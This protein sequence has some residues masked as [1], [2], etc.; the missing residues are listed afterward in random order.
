MSDGKDI[1]QVADSLIFAERGKHLTD[2]ETAIIIGVLN[3]C[4][5]SEIANHQECTEGHIKDVSSR[6]WQSF[7][8]LLGEDVTKK[9]LKS[10]LLR[11][12]IFNFSTYGTIN[13]GVIGVANNTISSVTNITIHPSESITNAFLKGKQTAKRE[14]A[15]K[16]MQIG[17]NIDQICQVLDLSIEEINLLI[18]ETEVVW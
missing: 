6:L 12:G 16:M 17:M 14:T 10:T 5:Y 9:N 11:R 8:K 4:T 1:L 3:N 15:I 2:V 13:N 18:G 7:S